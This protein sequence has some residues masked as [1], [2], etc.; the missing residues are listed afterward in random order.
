M[1]NLGNDYVTLMVEEFNQIS[2]S[3]GTWESHWEEIAG[4]VYPEYYGAFSSGGYQTPGAKRT[5]QQYD[6]T[7]AIARGRFAAVMESMLTPRNSFWH[8]L[9]TEDSVL[10][11]SRQVKLYFEDVLVLLHFVYVFLISFY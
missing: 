1:D 10:K 7:A 3:R 6:S 4:R 8:A 5:Q 2:G 9:T 11:R